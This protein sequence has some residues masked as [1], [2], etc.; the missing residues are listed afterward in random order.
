MPRRKDR[1][2]VV[3][4]TNVI[5]GFY[6]SQNPVSAISKLY[7]LW[8]DKRRLQLIVCDYIVSEYLEVVERVGV[9]DQRIKRLKELLIKHNIVTHVSLGARPTDSRDPDDNV[10]LATAL[11]GGAKFLITNDD[12]LL[13]IPSS[14]KSKFKF[15]ILTP[16]ESIL[17]L[18]G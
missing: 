13:D 3:F 16:S 4:D 10:L 7:S 18:E 17:H 2:P 8:R 1:I 12:D 15:S 9:P 11:V 5:V 14:S 6:L